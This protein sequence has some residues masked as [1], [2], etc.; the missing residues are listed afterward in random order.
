MID[1]LRLRVS[2]FRQD[3]I[4]DE[5]FSE[6]PNLLGALRALYVR[7][8]STDP[9]ADMFAEFEKLHGLSDDIG[10]EFKKTCDELR[11]RMRRDTEVI[12]HVRK[13]IFGKIFDPLAVKSSFQNKLLVYILYKCGGFI[14][15]AERQKR[16]IHEHAIPREC[17]VRRH[18]TKRKSQF[19]RVLSESSYQA[20]E[21]KFS[22][23]GSPVS[24]D[25][26]QNWLGGYFGY[27]GPEADAA[28]L[29]DPKKKSWRKEYLPGPTALVASIFCCSLA[30]ELAKSHSPHKRLRVT[31][32]RSLLFGEEEALQQSC[33]YYGIA[34]EKESTRGRTFPARNA[35]IGLAYGS[36]KIVRSVRGVSRVVL[37]NAMEFLNL[38]VASSRMSEDVGFVLAMPLL[39]PDNNFTFPTPVAGVIYIDST[40]EGFFVDDGRLQSLADMASSF[41]RGLVD[42]GQ[43]EFGRVRNFALSAIIK[44]PPVSRTLPGEVATALQFVPTVEPPRCADAFQFNFDY[45][46]FV[47]TSDKWLKSV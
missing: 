3:R 2:Q 43:E 39:Q 26:R 29:P 40:E 25:D 7:F 24:I 32:H 9:P 30:A 35:T 46:D 16:I 34:L 22:Q 1:L 19:K 8:S 27:P 12:L 37:R 5:I 33:D 44:I 11:Q 4:L 17:Q 45:S 20:L 18:G 15:T 10:V 6:K 13:P 14:P 28:M 42:H 38:N 47:P 36:R 41:L 23:S 31:L 21:N